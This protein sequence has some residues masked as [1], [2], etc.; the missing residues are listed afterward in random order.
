VNYE[1]IR[2]EQQDGVATITLN[3]PDVLNAQNNAMRLELVDAVETPV[4]ADR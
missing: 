3:R 2:L 1:T 4:G